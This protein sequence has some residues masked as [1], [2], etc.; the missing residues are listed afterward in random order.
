MTRWV[1]T[2]AAFL[3]V[4]SSG[5]R[6]FQASGSPQAAVD[7]VLAADRA[8]SAASAKTDLLAGLSAMF[9]DDVVIP[10]P[11]GQFVN[12]KAAVVAA[13]KTN[14]D[15][16]T[17]RTEWTPV[18][19]GVSADGQHGFTFGYMTIHRGDNT[20]LPL[21]Y[22]AYWVNRPEGWRVAAYKRS[23]ANAPPPSIAPIAPALP[24]RIVAQTRDAAALAKAKETLDEAERAFSRD[25]QRIGIGPA[26][27]QYGSADA[28]NLG[29]P[30]DRAVVIGAQNIGKMVGEGYGEGV[31]PVSWAPERVIVASSG[32][33]GVTIGWIT[34][35]TPSP[36][37]PAQTPFFTI[38]RRAN[39]NA[40]W[41]YV[42]E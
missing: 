41:K 7:E 27:V 36:D 6:A 37:R 32:D 17:S 39:A 33:L 38:W 28:I 5:A 23:R 35:N 16:L 40:P 15:N 12:G 4:C 2:C 18:R 29:R 9:A 24:D 21:K 20:D 10:M 25:A 14:A 42:A 11:P 1:R 3:I 26:F 30:D 8:F 19:G 34:P 31:S 22:L 13:L